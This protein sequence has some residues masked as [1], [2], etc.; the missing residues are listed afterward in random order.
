MRMMSM[1]SVEIEAASDWPALVDALEAA[2]RGPRAQLD[3]LLLRAGEE[4]WLNRAAW[5]EG[6]ALGLKSVTIFPAN[7][8][9]TPPL[10]SINGVMM[11]FSGE[12]GEIEAV[13][14]GAALTVWKTVADSALGV[15]QLAREDAEELLIVGAGTIARRAP[16]AFLAVCPS[17]KCVRLWNRTHARAE[18]AVA[19]L[20]ERSIAAEIADDLEAAA[21]KSD[22]ISCATMSTEPVIRGDW[23]KPGA[24][25]DLIGAYRPDMREADDA[26]LTRGRLF[27]DCRD[28]T[29][30]EIG[31]LIIPMAAG[32]I[33]AADVLADHYDLAQGAQGR[34]GPDDITIFKNGGGAHLDLMT[35]R[36]FLART[37]PTGEG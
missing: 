7:T 26:A 32:V 14:D 29:I 33:S 18:E 35:A 11:V 30:G 3:D 1:S 6:D 17:L 25:L 24:H 21:R 20:R 12:T 9:R 2:H 10:A 4:A 16:E 36:F 19:A 23:L 15:K 13:L 28:T 22:I 37:P 31:E 34:T 27:V 8:S 5:I